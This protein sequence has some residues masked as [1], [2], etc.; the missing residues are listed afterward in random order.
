MDIIFVLQK[1]DFCLNQWIN[2][3][4]NFTE[5]SS[6]AMNSPQKIFFDFK[7]HKG[8]KRSRAFKSL[9]F[10]VKLCGAIWAYFPTF[11]VLNWQNKVLNTPAKAPKAKIPAFFGL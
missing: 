2:C 5:A 8:Q 9:A 11:Q 3:N 1:L 6:Y 7:G 10:Y 4:Q